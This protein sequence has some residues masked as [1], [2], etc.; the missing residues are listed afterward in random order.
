MADLAPP[1]TALAEEN[2]VPDSA[3]ASWAALATRSPADP[4]PLLAPIQALLAAGRHAE[5]GVLLDAAQ[6]QFPDHAPFAIEAARAAQR[7]GAP[8]E[9][10]RRWQAVRERFPDLPQGYSAAAAALR[11][12]GDFDL[13]D[14]LLRDA[15]ERF[16]AEPLVVAEQAWLAH[17]RRDWAAAAGYW[18]AVRPRLPGEEAVYTGSARALR[19]LGRTDEADRL[20]RE[21]IARFPDRRSPLT[22]HAWL[23]FIRGDW[24]AAAE[25]WAA[26]HAR[27]P[28]HAEA[29]VK[30]AQAL[31]Q[32]GRD[33][34]AEPLLAEA[35]AQL[36]D[37]A[38]IA[39]EYAEIAVRR[40]DWAEAARRWGDAAARFPAEKVFS[41]RLHAAREHMKE[42]NP[43]AGPVAA[44]VA[45]FAPAPKPEAGAVDPQVRD[46]VLQFESL[47][48]HEL[49]C[50]FGIVQRD[51]GAEPLGLLRWADMPYEGLVAALKS[52]FA[53]VG[54]EENTELFLSAT[55]DGP[56]E[57]CTRDRRGFMFMRTFISADEMPFDRVYPAAC[58]R[59]QF[60]ARKLIEDL[61]EGNKVFVFRLTDRHL[62]EAELGR[63]HATMR[64][65][66]D[67]ALLYV[68]RGDRAHPNGTV[69]LAGPGLMVGYI[70]CFKI[71]PAGEISAA[72]STPSWLKICQNAWELWSSL[73][74]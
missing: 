17:A 54:S 30:E 51:C 15:A 44:M 52:R 58:R 67:N 48:G 69:E 34:D 60:L 37:A 10:L 38:E 7:H 5:A 63:L 16:P 59:L 14:A 57:Y 39:V 36:P 4:A 6:F 49:G 64:S 3:L 66:G 19:E 27:F 13:A 28:D 11:D 71:S 45:Q 68:R 33:D 9:A 21:A 61:E 46:L 41:H 22:E 47:G 50:E 53:G 24:P 25:R 74:A 35:M 43:T 29:Y 31:V 20:L 32:L 73:R 65:Y 18:E 55:G 72:S 40:Q 1:D 62:T 56:D 26:V 2:G 42:S 23:A 8:E 12:A 70:D